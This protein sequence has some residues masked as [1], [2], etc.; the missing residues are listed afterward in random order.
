MQRIWIRR[1]RRG[2]LFDVRVQ[3]GRQG[4]QIL[5]ENPI[6]KYLN[7]RDNF[8]LL[9]IGLGFRCYRQEIGQNFKAQSVLLRHCSHIVSQGSYSETASQAHWI[10]IGYFV[11]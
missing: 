1:Q 4:K 6:G 3:R 5:I 8:V 11:V 7:I 2:S 10:G 9:F